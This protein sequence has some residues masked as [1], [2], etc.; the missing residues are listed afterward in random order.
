M[1]LKKDISI[2]KS[3]AMTAKA[4]GKAA[5]EALSRLK[6]RVDTRCEDFDT[7]LEATRRDVAAVVVLGYN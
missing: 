2:K 5:G 4:A 1:V 6:R 7:Q 3:D